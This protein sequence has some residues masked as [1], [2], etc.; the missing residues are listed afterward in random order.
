MDNRT[1]SFT[2]LDNAHSTFKILWQILMGLAIAICIH[3]FNKEFMIFK[4]SNQSFWESNFP[5]NISLFLIFILTFIRFF[6]GD[7]RYIDFHYSEFS[8]DYN[9]NSKDFLIDELSKLSGGRMFFDIVLLIIHGIIFVFL[10]FAISDNNYFFSVYAILMFSN[11]FWLTYNSHLRVKKIKGKP[12]EA[13][14]YENETGNY[15]VP[16]KY[17]PTRWIK[18][19]LVALLLMILSYAYLRNNMNVFHLSLVIICLLDCFADFLFTWRFY[20]P[21]LVDVMKK[22]K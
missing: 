10:G 20:A 18:I 14:M 5:Y 6:W 2:I 11:C 21:D 9:N 15:S 22:Y 12:N 17:Y 7:S 13:D 4:N 8:R 16:S 1:L 19:N 3:E